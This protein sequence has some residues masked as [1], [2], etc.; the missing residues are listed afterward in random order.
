M[1]NFHLPFLK[2]KKKN[3]WIL[4]RHALSAIIYICTFSTSSL[5]HKPSRGR[6]GRKKSAQ[7]T[8]ML[9]TLRPNLISRSLRY[10]LQ[11][12]CEISQNFNFWGSNMHGM[13][14]KNHH[15]LLITHIPENAHP[16]LKQSTELDYVRYLSPTEV[17]LLA[18]TYTNFFSQSN[19]K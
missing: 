13:Q 4:A 18:Q 1:F 12:F 14:S 3:G 2:K 11:V 7:F 10:D 9:C 15:F 17:P 6:A 8:T 19:L 16:E 5:Q